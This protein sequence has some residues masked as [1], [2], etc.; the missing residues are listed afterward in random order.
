MKKILEALTHS[1][2]MSVIV[3]AIVTGLIHSST[4]V[5]VMAENPYDTRLPGLCPSG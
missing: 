4:A 1:K 3:G 5:T 2:F